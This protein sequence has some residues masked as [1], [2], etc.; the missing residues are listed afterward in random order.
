VHFSVL[1]THMGLLV[2]TASSF[3]PQ[4]PFSGGRLIVRP[5]FTHSFAASPTG[6]CAMHP[7]TGLLL[8]IPKQSSRCA[9]A[10]GEPSP[11][12]SLRT[13]TAVRQIPMSVITS[14]SGQADSLT[15]LL[16]LT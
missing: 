14:S 5:L 11:S 7:G 1:S 2:V 10:K 8:L 4:T 16:V 3:V 9:R 15:V 13:S 6:S 12:G